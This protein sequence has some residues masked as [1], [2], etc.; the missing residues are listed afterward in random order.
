[1]DK[2]FQVERF[3]DEECEFCGSDDTFLTEIK[4]DDGTVYACNDTSFCEKRS[5]NPELEKGHTT[6]DGT[7][8]WT[9]QG[10]DDE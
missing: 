1:E 3:D 4:T 2:E 6:Q 5:E 7:T 8:D 10:G 9:D